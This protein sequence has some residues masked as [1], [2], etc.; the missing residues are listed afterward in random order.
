ME[1]IEI[2]HSSQYFY[3]RVLQIAIPIML[4]QLFT[5][6]LSVIDTTMVSVLG[7]NAIAA[8]GIGANF[9]FLIVMIMFGFLSGLGIFIAQYWGS[10]EIANIHKVFVITIIIGT[11]VS[12]VF[13]VVV[14]FFPEMIIGLYNNSDDVVQSA[15]IKNYGV[16]Y[17]TIV[18]FSYFTMTASFVVMMLMRNVERVVFPQIVSIF[19]VLINTALNYLLI[20][21][22]Y[23]FPRLEVEGAAIATVISSTIGASILILSMVFS[24]QEVFQVRF[25]SMKDITGAF[26]LKLAKKATPVAINEAIWGLGMSAYLMAVGYISA[27]AIA[28]VQI[29]N[30]IMGLFWVANAGISTACAIMI[31]NKLGENKLQL[32]KEWGMRFTK[33]SATAG[34]FFGIMLFLL[35][36]SIAGIFQ[37]ASE[38]VRSNVTLL[39]QVFSF[40]VPIKFINALQ[41]VGTLRA[42]GDTKAALVFE[43]MPLWLVGVPLAFILSIYTSLP[44]Y[45]VLG[46]ANVEEIIK[47]ILVLT[48]FRSYKWVRNLTLEYEA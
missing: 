34:V 37:N 35:S 32:A 22:R 29:S 24:K 44:L 39:L 33:L 31:G 41:I 36:P 30:Q 8:V 14:H 18:S 28:S 15:I 9:G 3:K 13:F 20:E 17:L 11:I 5:S 12:S 2:E 42:G 48:R 26:V 27:E 21:G 1:N 4:A 47:L 46:I 19:V 6:L 25:Q 7:D 23:G 40:Y 10:K 16:K 38:V 43:I 45:F